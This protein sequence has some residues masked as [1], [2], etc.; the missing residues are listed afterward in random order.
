[1]GWKCWL[2][3]PTWSTALNFRK[4]YFEFLFR[5]FSIWRHHFFIRYKTIVSN[6]PQWDIP[7]C[8]KW[9]K[10]WYRHKKI[11]LMF[12]CVTNIAIVICN[13]T[14]HFNLRL[15]H[16]LKSLL[17]PCQISM[18]RPCGRRFCV[19]PPPRDKA[20]LWRKQNKIS[21]QNLSCVIARGR[22]C[23][24]FSWLVLAF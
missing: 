10:K 17:A 18:V 19:S 12:R 2:I 3:L 16:R 23:N 5:K 11:I 8:K 20:N 9:V 6:S 7:F 24:Q 14:L 15:T 4:H 1:M 21:L 22:F 13:V